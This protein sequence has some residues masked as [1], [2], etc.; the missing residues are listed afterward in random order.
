M[1]NKTTKQ[2][3]KEIKILFGKEAYNFAKKLS[4]KEI[5]EAYELFIDNQIKDMIDKTYPKE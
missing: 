5:Q 4:K 2:M 1:K 3:L